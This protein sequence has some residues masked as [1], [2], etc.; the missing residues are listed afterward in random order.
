MEKLATLDA[1]FF[2]AVGKTLTPLGFRGSKAESR[3]RVK[4]PT[5]TGSAHFS[6]IRHPGVD[7]DVVLNLAVRIDAA[8]E[9]ANDVSPML[10][11]SERRRIATLGTEYGN[12]TQGSQRRWTIVTAE[13]ARIVGSQV[14]A[15]VVDT[16]IPFIEKYADLREALVRLGGNEPFHRALMPLHG[17]RASRSVILAYLLR[18][19]DAFEMLIK[20]HDENLVSREDIGL[21]TFRLLVSDL[22]KRW[23]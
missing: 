1:E 22:R 17:K 12:W 8:E 20:E 14:A 4:T 7:F 21:Q 19:K 2:A 16:G 18:D 10:R 6:L 23:S 3:Y 15:A 11:P 5:G 9:I 13:D